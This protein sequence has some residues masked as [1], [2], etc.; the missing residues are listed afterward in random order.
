MKDEYSRTISLRCSTCG[1]GD[2]EYENEEGPIRCTGCDR[3]YV[4]DELIQE[5]GLGI[6]HGIEE[7]MTEIVDDVHKE[8]AKIFKGLT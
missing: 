6:E 7:A 2:F 1:G 8:F 5:N 4:R 3:V